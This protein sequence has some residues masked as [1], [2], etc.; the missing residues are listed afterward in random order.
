[1]QQII[2]LM[3]TTA[4]VF[5]TSAMVAF[6]EEDLPNDPGVTVQEEVQPESSFAVGSAED[7]DKLI[8][9]ISLVDD[10]TGTAY[11]KAVTALKNAGILTGYPDG[12][13]M[14][15]YKISRAEAAVM[16]YRAYKKD[17]VTPGEGNFT[18]ISETEYGWAFEAV[19]YC[20]GA[21][22]INGYPDGS[23]RPANDISY[24]ELTAMLVRA[25]GSIDTK[26][27]SYPADYVAYAEGLEFGKDMQGASLSKDGTKPATRG[28]MAIMIFNQD[29]YNGAEKPDDPTPV[30]PSD[31]EKD[32]NDPSSKKFSGN[33]YGIILDNGIAVDDRGDA[34]PEADFMMGGKTFEMFATTAA[35]ASTPTIFSAVSAK[36]AL[37]KLNISSGRV[38]SVTVI[39]NTTLKTG[40][41][42]E[43]VLLTKCTGN[44]GPFV[45]VTACDE[46]TM[47][48]DDNGTD[49]F[50]GLDAKVV[51]VLTYS[52]GEFKYELGSISDLTRDCYCAAYSIDSESENEANVLIVMDES[53]IPSSQSSW[54]GGTLW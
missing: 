33:A 8:M 47:A 40:S 17:G 23:F 5:S 3:L 32:K 11:E 1:M 34:V 52:D 25:D 35:A 13:M 10:I 20:Q 45:K 30:N 22:L 15:E 39:D 48:F 36:N 43:T 41:N 16:F 53:E 51:Y 9:P 19:K 46:K 31:D 6:A 37:V 24:N 54:T 2:S 12:S 18:D 44:N 27:M 42:T 4:L 38:N 26:E 21:G 49:K 50:I 14:P 29:G 28:N 7:E